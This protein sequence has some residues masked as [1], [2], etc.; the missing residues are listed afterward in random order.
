MNLKNKF[1]IGFAQSDPYYG[2]NRNNNFEEV[3]KQ[4]NKNNFK[5]FDTA[6]NYKFSD[7]FI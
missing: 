7:K 2:I 4:I 1:I 6:E 5:L 3:F